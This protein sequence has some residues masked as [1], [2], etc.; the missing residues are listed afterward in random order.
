MRSSSWNN[1]VLI[2]LKARNIICRWIYFNEIIVLNLL[3]II[4]KVF[5]WIITPSHTESGS[6]IV[7]ITEASVGFVLKN[8]HISYSVISPILKIVFP[9]RSGWFFFIGGIEIG[10]G[11]FIWEAHE[12]RKNIRMRCLQST[13]ENKVYK[14]HDTSVLMRNLIIFLLK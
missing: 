3:N 7:S 9:T 5:C 10:F 2:P 4:V 13:S 12:N 11:T 14:I 1:L 8:S 6:P